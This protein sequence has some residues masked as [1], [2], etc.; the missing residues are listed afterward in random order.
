ML[1]GSMLRPR[2]VLRGERDRLGVLLSSFRPFAVVDP[3]VSLTAWPT[4]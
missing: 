4:R 1:R 2:S 3:R